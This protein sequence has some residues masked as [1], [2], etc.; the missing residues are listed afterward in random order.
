MVALPMM[1]RRSP[2]ALSG[3]PSRNY[4]V[5]GPEF[6]RRLL[7]EDLEALARHLRAAID[8]FVADN[9]P[10]GSDGQVIRAAQR[11][12]LIGAAGEIARAYGIVPWSEGAAFDAA[13]WALERWIENRGGTDAAEARHAVEQVRRFFE[14]HGKSRFEPIDD[15]N[16]SIVYNRAGW[17]SGHGE[18]REWFVP[19]ETWKFEICAGMD[20]TAVARFLVE[21]GMMRRVEGSFQSV[22]RIGGAARRVYVLTNSILAGGSHA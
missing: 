5:A 12:G 1:L 8:E 7:K 16:H 6:L 15:D 14:A 17:R 19:P 11:L 2:M 4:G 9:I 10:Q 3:L 21:A 18:D 13:A 20:A 22:R